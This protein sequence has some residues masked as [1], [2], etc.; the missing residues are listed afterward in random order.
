V[1]G[2]E[3]ITDELAKGKSAGPE[4]D[5]DILASPDD[6]LL[7]VGSGGADPVEVM[8]PIV[9]LMWKLHGWVLRAWVRSSDRACTLKMCKR[10]AASDLNGVS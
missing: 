10:P 1:L 6:K 5:E 2:E 8:T 4:E 7:S 9:L 3:G